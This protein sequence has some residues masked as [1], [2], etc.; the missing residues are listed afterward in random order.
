MLEPAR[1]FRISLL[2]LVVWSLE[3]WAYYQ[4]SIAFKWPLGLGS[5]SLF[6]AAVNFSSLIPAAP[7]GIGVIEAAA[8]LALVLIGVHRE[9]ALA[10]VASQHLIQILGGWPSRSVFLF[11]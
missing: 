5:L 8:T 6:L 3:L 2:S 7:A 1:L 11:S 10:M 9:T 4:V